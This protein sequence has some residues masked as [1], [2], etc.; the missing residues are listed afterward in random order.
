MTR[1]EE[2]ERGDNGLS[3]NKSQSKAKKEKEKRRKIKVMDKGPDKISKRA[4]CSHLFCSAGSLL[5][6]LLAAMS[7]G[8]SRLS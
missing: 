3:F 4:V 2:M 8:S 1:W 7:L 5:E 6:S